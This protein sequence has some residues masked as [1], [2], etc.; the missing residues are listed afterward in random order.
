MGIST[1]DPYQRRSYTSRATTWG[2]SKQHSSSIQCSHPT[3]QAR[4]YPPPNRSETTSKLRTIR[5]SIH[6]PIRLRF[7]SASFQPHP[8]THPPNLSTSRRNYPKPTTDLTLPSQNRTRRPTRRFNSPLLPRS[9]SPRARWDDPC[10]S[11][12]T[13]IRRCMGHT[14][15]LLRR[16]IAQEPDVRVPRR[17]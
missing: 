4:N 11:N 10:R 9:N 8:P 2:I 14:R 16:K 7:S 12:T 3:D 5:P 1:S 13:C 6:P 15:T 17:V